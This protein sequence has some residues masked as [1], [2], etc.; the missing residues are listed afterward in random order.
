MD[1]MQTA[2]FCDFGPQC[3][4]L[5][6]IFSPQLRAHLQ[7]QSQLFPH[8]ITQANFAD[9]ASQ[10]RG[11]EAIFS[12][13]GMW[14][15][16]PAQLEAM[17]NLKA[18]FYA[19]GSVRYFAVPLLER[20][21]IV[22]SAWTA[23]AVPVAEFCLAQILLANKGYWRNMAQYREHEDY[24]AFRGRGNYGTTVSVLGAGQIGRRV[25]EL[26]RPFQLRVTCF[27][28]FLSVKGAESL[29]VEKVELS[30]AF[31]QGDVVSNHLANVPA[32]VGMLRGEHFEAMPTNA[33]FINTGRGPTVNHDD[34]VRV[35]KA[36][37]DFSALLD[38]TEPEPLP[39][40]HALRTLPNAHLTSH[41]AGSIGDEVARMG[42]YALDEFERWKRG[43]PLRYAVTPQMLETMA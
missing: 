7:A 5:N 34:L 31:A 26:L 23:N 6:C 28:P 19:A 21:I 15:L 25:I 11:V 17:P 8:V 33:T 35:L 29:G 2:I 3:P 16:S 40:G 39:L 42:N 32:T 1:A 13:W 37:P 30:V 43:E 9:F 27:D 36:R 41:I 12:T 22:T 24:G 20:G 38:V 4:D 18:V 10:L 14:Q